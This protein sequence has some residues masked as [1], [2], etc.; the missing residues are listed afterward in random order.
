MMEVET[1]S[2]MG[3]AL[4]Q[5]SVK[6]SLS[7]LIL[8]LGLILWGRIENCSHPQFTDEDTEVQRG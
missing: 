3:H 6:L 5:A 8:V 4:R 1:R 2:S 7:A